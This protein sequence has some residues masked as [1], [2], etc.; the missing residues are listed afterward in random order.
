M[1]RFFDKIYP[2]PNTGCWLWS[3]SQFK[4]GYGGFMFN[5][6]NTRAHRVSFFVKHGYMPSSKIDVC[7]KCDNRLCVNPDHLF[8]GTR[9]ENLHDARIKKRMV[10]WDKVIC[11][12]GHEYTDKTLYINS[13]GNKECKI[14]IKERN[15]RY[16]AKLNRIS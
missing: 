2:E 12:N 10:N 3:G 15:K 5:G 13:N 7:H 14:C 8:L 11:K 16:N 6:K 1:N 9:K 4:T